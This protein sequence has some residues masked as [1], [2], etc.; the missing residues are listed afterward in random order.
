MESILIVRVIIVEL[1]KWFLIILL[2]IANLI[3]NL[4][5]YESFTIII[6]RIRLNFDLTVVII[7]CNI[8]IINFDAIINVTIAIIVVIVIIFTKLTIK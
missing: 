6:K 2:I 1:N 7:I 3:T 8:V 5:K 4:I